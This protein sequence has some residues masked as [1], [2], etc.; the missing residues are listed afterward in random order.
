MKTASVLAWT[1][2]DTGELSRVSRRRFVVLGFAGVDSLSSKDR[3]RTG[4]VRE[5]QVAQ[6]RQ[7]E[8]VGADLDCKGN[9]CLGIDDG[10]TRSPYH[11][12]GGQGKCVH[13]HRRF[14]HVTFAISF[15]G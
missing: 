7:W 8:A 5:I 10:P 1:C 12:G 14:L 13:H 9:V 6:V 4:T 3:T 15:S 11:A 2:F